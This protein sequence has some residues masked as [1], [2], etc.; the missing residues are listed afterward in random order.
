MTLLVK[1]VQI[2][3][4]K[5]E[6]PDPLPNP[7]F[8]MCV[9]APPRSGKSTLIV[10]FIKNK[11]FKYKWGLVSVVSPTAEF[12]ETYTTALDAITVHNSPSDMDGLIEAFCAS[13]EQND[14]VDHMLLVIDDCV[15]YMGKSLEK[16]ASKYRHYKISVIVATQQFRM[17]PPTVRTC[18]N[19]WI[20]YKTHNRKEVGKMDEEFSGQ[21][22]SFLA[23]YK[24]ATK[25]QFHFLFID[26]SN[27]LLWQD[28]TKEISRVI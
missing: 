28:F 11:V 19:Y 3:P 16:L 4:R 18:A 2:E 22:P 26:I 20:L 14:M 25:E 5:R 9:V 21:F 13:Q 8:F 24:K 6:V 7:P 15:G 23:N 17:L 1:P 10:N 12:D 27:G